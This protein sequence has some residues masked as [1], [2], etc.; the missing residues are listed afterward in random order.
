MGKVAIF[1]DGAYLSKVLKESFS[2][3]Q[4][5][6]SQFSIYLAN[7][8]PILRTYY[9]N[10]M[11]YKS[12]T[13]TS[14]EKARY[15]NMQRFISSLERLDRYEVKLGKLEY[16]GR[17]SDGTPI[18]Q[19]K[20]VDIL[21]GCDLVLLSAKQRIE[22]AILITGDS[23]FIPAIQ[24]AKNEGVEIELIYDV[25]HTPHSSLTQIADVRRA[26][27]QADINAVKKC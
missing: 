27:T 12:S 17:K 18:F 11:P 6:F 21:L 13:P 14:G 26:L 1:I 22:K 24:I 3:P 15:D 19:Q 8:E 16:R 2:S 4:I 23:D 25:A 5:D 9:Y 10:C 20:R 7:G